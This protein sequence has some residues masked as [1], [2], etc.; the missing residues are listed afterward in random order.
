MQ[1]DPY[2]IR[3]EDV[4]EVLSAYG[5]VPAEIREHAREHVL[6][7]VLDIDDIAR[8][9]PAAQPGERR[10]AALAAIEDLLIRDGYIDVGADEARVF[11][12]AARDTE[13]NDS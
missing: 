11:P 1:P 6:R 13:R 4:D 3:P 10:D 5:D 7:N 9:V 2:T 12:V 8:T